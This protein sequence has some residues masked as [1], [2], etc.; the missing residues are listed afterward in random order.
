MTISNSEPE[1]VEAYLNLKE[2]VWELGSYEDDT[3]TVGVP[4]WEY[5]L[6]G[7]FTIRLCKQQLTWLKDSCLLPL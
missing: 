5:L 1:N 6:G 7:S 3:L 2:K 4:A